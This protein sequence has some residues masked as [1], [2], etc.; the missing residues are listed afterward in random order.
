MLL[1][2]IFPFQII[3]GAL[4]DKLDGVVDSP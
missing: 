4:S 1:G 2:W 3:G